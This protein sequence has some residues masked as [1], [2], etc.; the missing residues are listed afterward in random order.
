MEIKITYS[1]CDWFR[2]TRKFKTLKGARA[3]AHRWVGEHPEMGSRYA[4]SGDGIG[5]VTVKGAT[6]ADLFP[7]K[8]E[9]S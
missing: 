3:Y 8:G 6:L 9:A 4:I 7:M 2:E 1:S 5:K